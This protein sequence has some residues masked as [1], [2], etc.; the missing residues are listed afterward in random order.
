M[1]FALALGF[2]HFGCTLTSGNGLHDNS[3]KNPATDTTTLVAAASFFTALKNAETANINRIVSQ[4]NCRVLKA[5][6][7]RQKAKESNSDSNTDGIQEQPSKNK[8]QGSRAFDLESS[9]QCE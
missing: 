4:T 2:T 5:D 1:T 6:L 8:S 3:F 9:L 7:N